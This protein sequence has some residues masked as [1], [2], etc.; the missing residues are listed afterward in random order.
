MNRYEKIYCKAMQ[1]SGS[2]NVS[3]L[4]SAIAALAMDME[5]YTGQTVEVSGPFGQR[6]EVYFKIGDVC[7]VITPSFENDGLKLY[8]DTGEKTDRYGA[9]TLE[10]I[11]GFNN[12]QA[13]LP[14]TF[15][16]IVKLLTH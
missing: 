13:P 3:W 6:A 14:D 15:E 2:L 10:D 5:E 12:I 9:L 8:Y 16:E 4:D 11:N 1:R 7:T